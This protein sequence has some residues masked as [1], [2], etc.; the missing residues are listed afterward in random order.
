MRRRIGALAFALTAAL[1]AALT[2]GLTQPADAAAQTEIQYAIVVDGGP[3]TAGRS[4][5]YDATLVSAGVPVSGATLTLM[6][7]T[8]GTSTYVPVGS[9]VTDAD[10]NAHVAARLWRTSALQ[11]RYSGDG[12]YDPAT[13][14]PFFAP[15][16][17]QVSARA[18]DRT[19][20]R[21]QRLVIRGRT[22]PAKP[23]QRVTLMRGDIPFP[24]STLPAPVKVATAYV[25]A[26]GT[27]RIAHAFAKAGR[28]QLFVRVARGGANATG[29]SNY[30]HV[31]VR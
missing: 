17:P 3:A 4:V 2:L 20:A 8:I 13:A 5:G 9:G 26:D 11:W 18:N 14:E 29:Y 22:V 16:A 21:G 23:G 15:V 12:A 25:R 1:T 6:A 10:G 19:L 24:L 31:R 7:R 28:Q 27:Y 30:V